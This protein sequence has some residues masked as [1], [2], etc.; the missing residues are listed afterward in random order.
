MDKLEQPDMFEP[1]FDSVPSSYKHSDKTR[2][3][4][5]C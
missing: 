5:T 2:L 4:L 1:S 3:V